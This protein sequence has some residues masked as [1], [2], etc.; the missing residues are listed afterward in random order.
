DDDPV[1][2]RAAAEAARR[3]GVR[4]RTAGFGAGLR[5]LS[6]RGWHERYGVRADGAV[7]VRPD[8]FVAWR[9]AGVPADAAGALTGALRRAL[10]REEEP[11]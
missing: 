7:L 10:A 5:D 11:A 9:S 8:G 4:L 3:A 6:E 2:A 1:W